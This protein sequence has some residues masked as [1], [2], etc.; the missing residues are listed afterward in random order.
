MYPESSPSIASL[1]LFRRR[2]S[3][4]LVLGC[5]AVSLVR[6]APAAAKPMPAWAVRDL[7]LKLAW[8][9]A[10]EFVMGSPADEAG[11]RPNEGPQ[12]TVTLTHGYWLGE[13]EVTQGQWQAIM[14]RSLVD[15]AR[16]AQT[17]DTQYLISG[18]KLMYMRDFAG[19]ARDGDTLKMIGNQAPDIPIYWVS[20][21]EAVEF[22]RRLNAREMAAGRLPAGYKFRLPTE[23]EWEYACRAGT[24]TA[25]YAGNLTINPANRTAPELDGIAWY[26]GN[27][28]TGYA[29]RGIDSSTTSE[30][31]AVN[32]GRAGPRPVAT[33]Q[34]NAWG[35][36]DMLGNA[37]E[38][39]WDWSG[40]YHGGQVTDP[41]GPS[42]GQYHVRRGGG[43]SSN[44]T[45]TRAAY[46]NWHE[47][48]YRWSNLGLRL[49]LGPVVSSDGAV[50]NSLSVQNSRNAAVAAKGK[51]AYYTRQFDLD[52]LPHYVP[53]QAVSGTIRVWGSNYFADGNLGQYWAE[54]FRKFH[55]E[56]QFT[57]NLKSPNA[58]LAALF[59]GVAD[60][61]VGKTSFESMLTYQREMGGLPLRVP[62]VTGSLDIAGWSNALCIYLHK[63]NPLVHLTLSQLDG[64]FGAA[65]TGGWQGLVWHPEFARGADQNIRTWG[66]LGLTG[67]WA[68]KPIHVYGLNLRDG[69][70]IVFSNRVLKGS[71]K[72]N[73]DLRMY[74]NYVGPDG[75]L[76]LS[77]TQMMEALDHDP[78]GIAYSG[79]AN[80]TAE[81]KRIPLATQEGGPFVEP[82]LA[83]V[84]NHTYLF[85]DELYLVANRLPGQPLDPK[86]KEFLR[87]VLSREG[88]EAVQRDGKYLPLTG[89]IVRE[90]LPQ[91]N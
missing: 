82:T 46:R 35:L 62:A 70:A 37:A 85:S 38:W 14:G 65:R 77:Y 68:D 58:P 13:T 87:Y 47:P 88:Q 6:A 51:K 41:T 11:R 2:A 81:T 56:I 21:E 63:D 40:E 23:A 91:L 53:Q 16:L 19:V 5:L 4:L 59:T 42:T 27:S 67:E 60:I 3:W 45:L 25:T 79:Y 30:K 76:V 1:P 28:A 57:F 36:Y 90:F 84:Q 66:Q 20:W 34:P 8:V 15:Q 22:C 33:K 74:A 89:E 44:A 78:L 10:G 73:E 52:G 48:T 55:P 43:W 26:S 29:G 7:R 80:L 83:S 75:K 49:A 18:K 17:D 71:D 72:W 9:P 61:G 39:C 69:H 50:R 86:V 54:G 31:K 24:T 64:I 32:A 12:T